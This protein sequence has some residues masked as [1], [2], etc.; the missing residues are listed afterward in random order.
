[1]NIL[2]R[3][4][5]WALSLSSVAS[6]SIIS[7][8]VFQI[9]SITFLG[10][11]IDTDT[12]FLALAF[13]QF[14]S[15]AFSILIIN[16]F[17]PKLSKCSLDTKALL[18]RNLCS[19]IFIYTVLFICSIFLLS[20]LLEITN[21]LPY[22]LNFENK[23]YFH[24]CLI[25]IPFNLLIACWTA[26]EYSN[27]NYLKIESLTLFS[28]I[29]SIIAV[30]LLK[31]SL[32]LSVLIYIVIFRLILL[33]LLLSGIE[34]F[35]IFYSRTSN[36]LF[37]ELKDAG[38]NSAN[39]FV[40]KSDN[41]I[42]RSLLMQLNQVGIVTTFSLAIQFILISSSIIAKTFGNRTLRAFSLIKDSYSLRKRSKLFLAEIF[43]ICILVQLLILFI[44]NDVIGWAFHLAN[45]NQEHSEDLFSIILL[46]SGVLIG[47][48]MRQVVE[49]LYHSSGISHN[50]GI[51]ST[52]FFLAY[53]VVKIIAFLNF[54]LIGLC[55]SI[56]F[57]YL[58]DPVF[59][60]IMFHLKNGF[61]RPI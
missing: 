49:N 1:L 36:I 15:M 44:G 2:F 20:N 8:F 7:L 34:A 18:I 21:L 58:L 16:I 19:E 30:I 17:V 4:Y 38:F 29:I 45:L 59:L 3:K 35:K 12:Y 61:K 13:P 46:V 42:D 9:L 40:T 60:L 6:L 27:D 24:L 48:S 51:Y 47:G 26:Y 5:N 28:T 31:D 52:Y 32:S 33:Y 53:L 57:Y 39:I 25:L 55:L 43:V 54:G 14:I 11:G 56:S 41:L 10:I 22:F 23:K 37:Y 50:F